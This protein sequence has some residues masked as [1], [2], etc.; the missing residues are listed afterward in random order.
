MVSPEGLS[1]TMSKILV[2]DSFAL[3]QIATGHT[4]K[5][6]DV[7]ASVL[8]GRLRV[9]VSGISFAVSC[10]MRTCWDDECRKEHTGGVQEF[11]EQADIDIA[12]PVAAESVAAGRLFAN[13]TDHRITGPEVL[14]ACH[15]IV[16]ARAGRH[17]L[18]S[19][20]RAAYCYTYL[21]AFD[22]EQAIELVYRSLTFRV[23]AAQRT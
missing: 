13:C 17:P 19:T 14:A 18:I 4:E 1:G 10:G 6:V 7:R 15:S 11:C 12:H 20:S 2:A 22:D 16:L 3:Y 21:S 9:L 23:G 8:A 5:A